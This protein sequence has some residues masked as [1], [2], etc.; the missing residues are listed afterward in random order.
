MREFTVLL[1]VPG[2]KV[3]ESILREER[4]MVLWDDRNYSLIIQGDYVVS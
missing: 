2:W 1:P 4:D 3:W